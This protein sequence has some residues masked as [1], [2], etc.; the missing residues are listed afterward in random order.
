MLI[1]A[2]RKINSTSQGWSLKARGFLFAI[3]LSLCCSAAIK[4]NSLSKGVE[5]TVSVPFASASSKSPNAIEISFTNHSGKTIIIPLCSRFGK[6]TKYTHET[7]NSSV[8]AVF[9]QVR[10]RWLDARNQ[11]LARGIYETSGSAVRLAPNQSQILLVPIGEYSK[12][13]ARQL[14][15]QFDNRSVEEAVKSFNLFQ[16]LPPGADQYFV[17]KITIEWTEPEDWNAS[18]KSR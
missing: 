3:L 7:T 10:Y 6:G 2:A 9:A 14:E 15:V 16:F 18:L 12:K 17:K 5:L 13:G 1:A 4:A 8:V 11:E